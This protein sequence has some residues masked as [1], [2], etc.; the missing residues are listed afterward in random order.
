[1][2]VETAADGAVAG[3]ASADESAGATA[4]EAAAKAE[5]AAKMAEEHTKAVAEGVERSLA[6]LDARL[7]MRFDEPERFEAMLRE[8]VAAG[9]LQALAEIEKDQLEENR[10]V[11]EENRKAAEAAEAAREARR[12][13]MPISPGRCQACNGR[14]VRHTCGRGGWGN[15]KKVG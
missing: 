12:Q 13:M 5:E 7:K 1:M 11:A 14:H 3:G 4:E 9:H 2:E 10:R 15:G 8:G 6:R